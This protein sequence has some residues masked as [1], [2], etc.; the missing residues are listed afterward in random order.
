[1]AKAAEKTLEKP[2][3]DIKFDDLEDGS[4]IQWGDDAE[5]AAPFSNI[6]DDSAPGG[7]LP[8]MPFEDADD[9]PAVEDEVPGDG[10]GDEGGED[11]AAELRRQL[12]ERDAEITRL[13]SEREADAHKAGQERAEARKTQID[14]E[15]GQV[16]RDLIEAAE[17]GDTAKQVELQGKMVDLRVERGGLAQTAARPA[18]TAPRPA[19]EQPP[20]LQARTPAAAEWMKR[21]SW[22][23][24]PAHRDAN[25]A[26]LGIGMSLAQHEGM[27]PNTPAYYEQ[28]EAR[29]RARFPNLLPATAPA[30]KTTAAPRSTVSPVSRDDPPSAPRPGQ[31]RQIRLTRDQ[32]DNMVRF[33]LDPKNPADLR[34][35]ARNIVREN[36]VR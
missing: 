8:T 5:V 10:T 18:E 6:N 7:R 17:D 32:L 33:G 23:N 11:D 24:S 12:A 14:A 2:T 1:M 22:I 4:E 28:L 20:Q 34:E 31:G 13:A 25:E 26:L 15:L 35:Y 3:A 16:N 21:H 27:D 36:T 30:K 9:I 19:A 29:L